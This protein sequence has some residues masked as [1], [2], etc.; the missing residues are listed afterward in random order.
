M[1]EE[2]QI[3]ESFFDQVGNA[4]SQ[5]FDFIRD[6][7][8]T[9]RGIPEEL[10]FYAPEE[11]S[12]YDYTYNTRVNNIRDGKLMVN[13]DRSPYADMIVKHAYGTVGEDIYRM[14][15]GFE[16]YDW[17][18]TKAVCNIVNKV[19]IPWP[20]GENGLPTENTDWLLDALRGK[21]K[22]G[23]LFPAS[24][25]FIEIGRDGLAAGDI[26]ILDEY[27]GDSDARDRAL[28]QAGIGSDVSGKHS[29][30]VTA[31][32]DD[33]IEIVH[34]GG[35]ESP[36]HTKFWF[37]ELLDNQFSAAFRFHPDASK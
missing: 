37:N 10:S 31:V 8:G 36:V 16:K 19:G 22:P 3:D 27:Q 20:T 11:H 7:Y 9:Y 12:Y 35:I 18:C 15:E 25:D 23:E 33:K 2:Q 21:R 6:P 34:E 28:R 32:F 5:M 14:E 4:A 30:L 17:V 26:I 1:P 24:K 13:P 29:A